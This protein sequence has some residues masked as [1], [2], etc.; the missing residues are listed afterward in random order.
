MKKFTMTIDQK[1]KLEEEKDKQAEEIKSLKAQLS[2]AQK[3]NRKLKGGIFGMTFEPSKGLILSRNLYY[4]NVVLAGLL[5]GRHEEEVFGFQGNVLK[6][7][8]MVHERA[9]KAMKSMVKAL[10]PYD[11]LIRLQG[12]YNFLSF[13]A[14]ILSTLDVLYAFICYFI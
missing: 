7:L 14:I 1:N 13:H 10:W 8:L 12:I 11:S 2:D 5:T 9:R 6:E 4:Y 3:E